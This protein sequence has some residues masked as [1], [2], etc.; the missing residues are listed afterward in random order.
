MEVYGNIDLSRKEPLK[1]EDY[2]CIDILNPRSSYP[3]GKRAAE[4]LCSA[5]YNEFGVPVKVARL[6]QTLGAGV[7]YNDN[8]V[9][10]QFARNIVEKKDIVLKTKGESVRNYIYVTDA[11]TAIFAML[12]KG[13]NGDVYNVANPET[14]CSI[15]EMA[16]M[17]CEKYKTSK[18]KIEIDDKYYPKSTMTVLNVNK[19]INDTGW[20]A[21]ISLINAYKKLINDFEERKSSV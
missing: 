21:E 16:E 1:E 10:A 19:M 3:V 9:F 7:D 11:I 20:E 8:R 12:E 6:A 15:K 18:L 13:V 2:G 14:A 17:L 5:Y 4:A